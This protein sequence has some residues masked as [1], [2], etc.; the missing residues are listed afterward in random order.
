MQVLW[1]G[2]KFLMDKSL[3]VLLGL[4]L[5]PFGAVLQTLHHTVVCLLE[6]LPSQIHSECYTSLRSP[7]LLLAPYKCPHS[8]P[9]ESPMESPSAASWG[10]EQSIIS[11]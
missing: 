9:A 6:R 7:A 1:G 4:G 3:A 2:V 5:L 8:L 10:G 11:P